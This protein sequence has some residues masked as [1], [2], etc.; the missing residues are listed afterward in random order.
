MKKSSFVALMLGI[1]SVL[2][3]GSGMSMTSIQEWNAFIPGIVLGCLGILLGL[4]TIIVWRKMEHKT[5]VKVNIK[6]VLTLLIG[7][8]GALILGTGMCLIMIWDLLIIG[9]IVGVIGIFSL[10]GLIPLVKGLK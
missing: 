1:I 10:V 7:I 9:I 3:L 6:T 8:V 4:A 5:P 2:L